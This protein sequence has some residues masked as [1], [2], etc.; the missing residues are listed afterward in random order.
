MV[1]L[2][3]SWLRNQPASKI[4]QWF[5][6]HVG[7]GQHSK[8]NAIVAV[9]RKLLVALWHYVDFGEIP[10]GALLKTEHQAQ[11]QAQRLAAQAQAAAAPAAS[12]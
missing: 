4:S 11:V 12:T 3:W 5:V 7:D 8:T 6:R 1:E 10:A 2:G 9:A